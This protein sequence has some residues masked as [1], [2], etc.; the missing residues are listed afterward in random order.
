MNN[1]PLGPFVL[2]H[3]W[4]IVIATLLI[5]LLFG[6]EIRNIKATDDLNVFFAEDNPQLIAL[7][8]FKNTYG[9]TQ[10]AYIAI[11]PDNKNIYT[12]D[13]LTLLEDFTNKSWEIPYSRRVDSLQNFQRTRV[14]GD[15][16]S[17]ANA[18]DNA[19][20]LSDDSI[21]D[22]RNYASNHNVLADLLVA[23]D[24]SIAAVVITLNISDGEGAP[25]KRQEVMNHIDKLIA[26][27]K[28]AHPNV[29]F[30]KT[31]G[32]YVNQA[33]SEAM[34]K[35]VAALLPLMIGLMILFMIIF[36]RSFTAMLGTMFVVIFSVI[37][38]VGGTVAL[39][40][41][42]T[43]VTAMAPIVILTVGVAD[44]IHVIIS[45]F[46]MMGH[47]KSKDEAI[48]E[49]LRINHAPIFLTS[50]TT[51]IGFLSLNF[52]ESPPFR[53]M[54]NEVS[55]GVVA[56]YFLSILF[57]PA[58]LSLMP[59][60]TRKMLD[61]EAPAMERFGAYIT[62][63]YRAIFAVTLTFVI[64]LSSQI[65]RL[66]FNDMFL[67]Y[68]DKT[69]EFR[70]T[71]DFLM[72]NMVGLVA[73]DYDIDAGEEGGINNPTYLRDLAKFRQWL[74]AQP[75]VQYVGSYDGIIFELNKTMHNDDDAFY[76]APESRKLAS[77]YLLMYEMSLP[78]GREISNSIS[79]DRSRS[80]LSINLENAK[81]TEII[82]LTKRAEKWAKENTPGIK[83]SSGIGET[84]MFAYIAKRNVISNINGSFLALFLI[85]ISLLI[86]LRSIKLG[87]LSLIPNVLPLMMA[88]GAWAI[89]VGELG[90]SGGAV[91]VIALG[92][93]VDNT[94]HFLSKYL[95]A[96]RELHMDTAAAIHYS[97]R[98]V[99]V[100]LLITSTILTLG[101]SM[102]YGSA[103]KP[104]KDMG[105]LISLTV[106]FALSATYFIIPPLLLIFD[107]N[108]KKDGNKSK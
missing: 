5:T 105:L 17:V 53:D 6:F 58:F 103:F 23:R 15:D 76:R 13:N 9:E 89:L 46:H 104:T 86:A 41:T 101:F 45:M 55:I 66:E 10:N 75:K 102:L 97:F 83:L 93:I 78:M 28:T 56:A 74:L 3:R 25:E 37:I 63:H 90:M 21:A 30:Y 1:F 35:D 26:D 4:L 57:L 36:L 77:Q 32:V 51:F 94:I 99:G 88:F 98:T 47:G 85:S 2:R 87:L 106:A 67:E 54:G 71:N 48:L 24:G 14:L 52:N 11:A 65:P 50:V 49:T 92:I 38:A 31:G 81:T 59:M 42:M 29:T 16:L 68:F 33:F 64:A 18:F 61:D 96:K 44:S 7:K 82:E 80:R 20:N 43:N 100:A 69:I 72:E 34:L 62:K 19:K 70:R 12:R 39:G 84:V 40:I 91:L 107:A 95:L 22:L 73:F 60:K 8:G 79:D 108:K 27:M